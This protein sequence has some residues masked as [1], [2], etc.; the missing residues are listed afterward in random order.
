M[1]K[2]KWQNKLLFEGEGKEFSVKMKGAKGRVNLF[3]NVFH[4]SLPVQCTSDPQTTILKKV[5]VLERN[6]IDVDA[7]KVVNVKWTR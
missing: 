2:D 4:V 3:E 7:W 5:Y 6:V 1:W